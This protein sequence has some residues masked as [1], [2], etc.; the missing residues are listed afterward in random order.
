[1]FIIINAHHEDW[2]KNDITQTDLNRFDS[3]WSQIA[4]RFKDKS[5]SLIFEM[6]NEPYPMSL[7]ILNALNVRVLA[8]I[9]KTNPT[10]IVSY[11]GNMWS[12][13]AEMMTAT[14]PDDDYVIGYFHSYDPWS[15][16]GEGKG[17]WGTA[18]DRSAMKTTFD[19]IKDWSELHNIPVN[20]GEFGA[21]KL[22]DYNSRMLHYTAYVEECINHGFAYEVWDDGGDF[23]IYQRQTR[24]WNEIKDIVINAGPLN[25]SDL[26]SEIVNDTN[27]K[28]TWTNR[29]SANDSIFIE[30]GVDPLEME[31]IASLEGGSADFTDSGLIAGEFYYYRIVAH[32]NDSADLYSYPYKVYMMPYKR[33][34][35]TGNAFTVPG[36]FEAEDFD[37]GGELLTYHDADFTNVP[38]AYRPSEGVDIEA[39]STGG[40]HITN[41]AVGEWLEYTINVTEAG[42]YS[43]M[44]SV[45][46]I[47]EGGKLYFKF[48]DG[49][50]ANI[51]VPR[52]GNWLTNT[53][54]GTVI[55]LSAGEQIMRVNIAELP[56]FKIDKFTIS[57]ASSVNSA[58]DDKLLIYPNP[59]SN[60]LFIQLSSKKIL[61]VNIL[62]AN[63]K[64]VETYFPQSTD[65]S[66][67]SENLPAGIY[68][69]V[70]TTDEGVFRKQFIKQ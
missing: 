19:Q 18:A 49:R 15:F 46:A 23:R 27:I 62:S 31:K 3:I 41:V 28:L 47:T 35:Y 24:G 8:I 6:I 38:G 26:K 10:R 56:A 50:T 14:I 37:F 53:D 32:F 70:V 68:F 20:L 48:K 29:T 39:R 21:Q 12:N 58:V 63:G 54:A 34:P 16:A 4:V 5:D 59:V 42:N 64:T 69:I 1:L 45:S 52:T 66:I 67:S 22:C 61:Q 30:R 25:P 55:E 2:L 36:S 43:V 9:R 40:Y 57:K 13:S 7:E 65:C 60:E 33:N 17:T 44:A 11:S 51:T